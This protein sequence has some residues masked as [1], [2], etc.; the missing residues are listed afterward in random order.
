MIPQL[1]RNTNL[2][3]NMDGKEVKLHGHWASP[4][5][6]RVIWSLKIKAVEYDYVEENLPKSPLLLQYNPVY[7]KIPV[8]VHHDKPIA[9]S[10]V[11]MEYIDET[12]KQNPLLPQDP[13]ERAKARFWAKFVDEKCVPAI[14]RVFSSTGEEQQ[15]ALTE[16]RENWK[17][18]ESGLEGKRFFG[19][20]QIGF[21]D[22]ANAWIGYWTRIVQEVVGIKLIDEESV[23]LLAKWFRDILEIPLIK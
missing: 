22:V 3:T 19:G 12:W 21:A 23:P 16:V 9:E 13:Y 17:L 14:M 18:M 1:P 7:K 8:L 15:K 11:I 4:F 10:L 5:V 20:E 6:L 2:T